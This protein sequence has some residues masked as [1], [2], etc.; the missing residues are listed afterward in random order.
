MNSTVLADSDYQGLATRLP[1]AIT[2]FKR[3]RGMH[4]TEEQIAYNKQISHR[5]IIVEN[6]FGRLKIL[7]V[8]KSQKH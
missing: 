1:G 2:P 4:L 6:W 8:K 5:R 3:S 7:W